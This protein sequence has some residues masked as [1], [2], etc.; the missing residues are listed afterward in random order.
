MNSHR[1]AVQQLVVNSKKYH[2]NLNLLF[3]SLLDFGMVLTLYK[4]HAVKDSTHVVG[5]QML[6]SSEFSTDRLSEMKADL[7]KD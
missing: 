1:I 4:D 5:P 6:Y 3:L 2:N 7:I